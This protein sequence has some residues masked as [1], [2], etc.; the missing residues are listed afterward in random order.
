M[1]APEHLQAERVIRARLVDKASIVLTRP[2]V[3]V[4]VCAVRAVEDDL[5]PPRGLWADYVLVGNDAGVVAVVS[6][7][8]DEG[9]D[10]LEVV[11]VREREPRARAGVGEDAW[12]KAFVRGHLLER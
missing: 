11:D 6:E 3:N 1:G 4:V 7:R 10:R 12:V 8:D 2:T 5:D 9:E